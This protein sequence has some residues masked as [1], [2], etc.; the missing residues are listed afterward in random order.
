[1]KYFL[2][3][4]FLLICFNLYGTEHRADPEEFGHIL[5]TYH[6][7]LPHISLDETQSKADRIVDFLLNFSPENPSAIGQDTLRLQIHGQLTGEKPLRF[8]LPAFPFKS[9]NPKKVIGDDP[10]LGDLIGLQTLSHIALEI[11]RVH[12]PGALI[13]LIGD[14]VLCANALGI[15]EAE[16]HVYILKIR[17]LITH[18]QMPL[19]IHQ[20]GE[21]EGSDTFG[22]NFL[23]ITEILDAIPVEQIPDLTAFVNNEM[24]CRYYKERFKGQYKQQVQLARKLI[25]ERSKRFSIYLEMIMRGQNFIRLSVN[26]RHTNISE[27]LPIALVFKGFRKSPW[28]H[29]LAPFPIG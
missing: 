21:L 1:M 15:P 6:Q 8:L 23:A 2:Q 17:Q 27:K 13:Q 14:G 20:L 9:K 29:P 5:K 28:R 24:N 10:D 12:K 22:K 16:I 26:E 3:L 11:Q 25:P 7:T 4:F 19:Q 18:F